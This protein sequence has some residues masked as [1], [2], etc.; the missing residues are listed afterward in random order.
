MTSE[1]LG[2]RQEAGE[3]VP[4]GVLLNSE[5]WLW[6][7]RLRRGRRWVDVEAGWMGFAEGLDVE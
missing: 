3:E 2:R 4:A 6:R 1:R 7:G 5:R